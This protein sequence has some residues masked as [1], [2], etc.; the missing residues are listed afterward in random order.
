MRKRDV[1]I[2]NSDNDHNDNDYNDNDY[3]D[4]DYRDADVPTRMESRP[5]PLAISLCHS[6]DRGHPAAAMRGE[7]MKRRRRRYEGEV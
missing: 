3:R 4:A 2:L 1:V 5:R 7:R 6:S